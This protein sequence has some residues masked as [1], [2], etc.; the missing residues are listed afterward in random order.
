MSRRLRIFIKVKATANDWDQQQ[1]SS[2]YKLQQSM[3]QCRYCSGSLRRPLSVRDFDSAKVPA[4][5]INTVSNRIAESIV[6]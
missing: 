5:Q 3:S 1:L 2:C 6:L 4:G